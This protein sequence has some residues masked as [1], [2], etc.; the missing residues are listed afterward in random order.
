MT[1]T[2]DRMAEDAW[3]MFRIMGEFASGFDLM[4]ELKHPA[5]TIFGSARIK[6]E[7]PW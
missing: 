2:I 4:N 1:Q 7:N 3:R 5:V 6:P